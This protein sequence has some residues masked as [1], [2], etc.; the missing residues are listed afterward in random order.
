MRNNSDNNKKLISEITNILKENQWLKV[1]RENYKPITHKIIDP[2][3]DFKPQGTYYSKGGWLFNEIC[4]DLDDE[5]IFIEVD[6]ST[7]YR[8]TG[9]TPYTQTNSN[10][11][12]KKNMNDFINKYGS[13]MNRYSCEPKINIDDNSLNSLNSK[14]KSIHKSNSCYYYKYKNK[15]ISNKKCNWKKYFRT[16]KYPYKTHNGL[17]IYPLP[18]YKWLHTKFNERLI[19]NTYDVETLVLW[20]HEP[21]IRH[22][23]LGTIKEIIGKINKDINLEE[24]DFTKYLIPNLIEK[25]NKINQ[26]QK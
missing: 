3:G 18:S 19:F 11:I 26:Y 20:N 16:F 21:V 6:Y 8:I 23:N 9:K 7:I 15:C 12:Y 13:K 5:L 17:A 2:K 24:N 25:I 4:C 1:S 14:H 10:S 22:Y